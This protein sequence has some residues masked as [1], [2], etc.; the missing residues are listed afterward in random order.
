VASVPPSPLTVRRLLG[1][2]SGGTHWGR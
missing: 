2:V 1:R